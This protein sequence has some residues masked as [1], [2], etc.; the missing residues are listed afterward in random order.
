MSSDFSLK[1]AHCSHDVSIG[2]FDVVSLSDLHIAVPED[3]LDHLVVRYTQSIEVCAQP[4]SLEDADPFPASRKGRL[5]RG[6][7]DLR[8][9]R[10]PSLDLLASPQ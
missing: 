4:A 8:Q 1:F 5:D 9:R 6:G 10:L 2:V 7:R 3:R